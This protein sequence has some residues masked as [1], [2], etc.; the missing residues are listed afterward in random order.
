MLPRDPRL[1]QGPTLGERGPAN[2]AAG[3]SQDDGD[4]ER[5]AAIRRPSDA[6]GQSI[7]ENFA[8]FD[9]EL[10]QEAMDAL[11]TLDRGEEGRT[12]PNPDTFAR[13]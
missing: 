9:F 8:L 12:G 4:G 10:D 11:G 3:P 1:G 5:Y 2:T 7:P 6:K 13:A